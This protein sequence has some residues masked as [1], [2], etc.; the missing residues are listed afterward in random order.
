MIHPS[1]LLLTSLP[2]A[3]EIALWVLASLVATGLLIW[4]LSIVIASLCVFHSTLHRTSPQKWGRTPSSQ[5]ADTLAMDAEG[6]AWHEKNLERKTDVHIQNNGLNLYGE[7]YDMGSDRCVMILSGRTESLRYG[8]FFAQPYAARGWN[9]LVLDPRAHG[10]SDGKFNTLGFEESRDDLAWARFLHD[11]MGVRSILFHGI[12]I[13]AA[14][15]MLA[16]TSPDCPDYVHGI[17]TDGMFPNFGESMKNHLIERKKPIFPLYQLINLQFKLYTGH[18][19]NYGPINVIERLDR[20]ILMLYS[21]ED[22][23][24]LPVYAQ[25]LY[26]MVSHDQK[27]L[28]WFEHGAHSMLRITDPVHYDTTIHAFLDRYFTPVPTQT[29]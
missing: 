1:L 20:P 16:I 18:T 22:L 27:H 13:G 17:V 7:Y 26:D 19:M 15:G 29:K 14:G 2:P 9:V 12:C 6:M 10:K 25:K 28:E 3:A 4:A 11:E 24:S 21:R 8:Y 5:D 23:Y